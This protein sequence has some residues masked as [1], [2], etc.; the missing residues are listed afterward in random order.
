[1]AQ[2]VETLRNK[3]E[4]RGFG[5]RWCHWNFLLTESF[6]PHYGPGVDSACNRNEY[7]E[8]FLGGKGG[9][10]IGL[11]TL[12]IVLKSGILNLLEPS[13]PFQACNGIALFCFV[14]LSFA[15]LGRRP[16]KT[17]SFAL[18]RIR[19]AELTAQ[20]RSPTST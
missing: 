4:G 12:P 7:K 10:C 16:D 6:R 1:M 2:V 3:S 15:S 19:K 20:I 17:N 11:A 8:Y 18:E 14:L 9:R 13:G 5:S